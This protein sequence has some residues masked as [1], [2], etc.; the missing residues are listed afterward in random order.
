MSVSVDQ[1]AQLKDR[2]EE[3]E[4]AN[5]A[6]QN[7]LELANNE[8][9]HKTAILTQTSNEL[10][11][12]QKQYKQVLQKL[13]EMTQRLGDDL[14][15]ESER[16]YREQLKE[17]S[18]CIATL[19][20]RFWKAD[21]LNR[22]YKVH[23]YRY[24]KERCTCKRDYQEDAEVERLRRENAKWMNFGAQVAGNLCG[25]EQYGATGGNL[26]RVIM[27]KLEEREV[28]N[29]NEYEKLKR[30]YERSQ[31]YVR[32]V[33]AQIDRISQ[34]NKKLRRRSEVSDVEVPRERPRSQP[35]P[36]KGLH[37]HVEKLTRVTRKIKND[38][39]DLCACGDDCSNYSIESLSEMNHSV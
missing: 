39:R 7:Q 6:L 31:A 1:D 17:Q 25:T 3:L 33:Q 10:S 15:S 36:M 30:E 34:E 37:D 19:Q 23:G 18:I 20:D 21:H 2:V 22:L 14:T 13:V 4:K 24:E 27:K 38:Y 16:L 35:H 29:D 12:L 8:L 32:D 28:T 5:Q 26:R 9:A 11:D